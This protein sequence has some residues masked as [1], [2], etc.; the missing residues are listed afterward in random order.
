MS[1]CYYISKEELKNERNF[2]QNFL[3]EVQKDFREEWN[4][5]FDYDLIGSGKRRLVVKKGNSPW[6]LDYRLSFLSKKVDEIKKSKELFKLKNNVKEFI[7]NH[8]NNN[9]NAKLSTSVVTLTKYNKKG[10]KI[11]SYDFAIVNKNNQILKHKTENDVQWNEIAN[12]PEALSR[13][14]EIKYQDKWDYFREKF[15][16]KKC[17]NNDN[18]S[19]YSILAMCIKETLEHFGE[20]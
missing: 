16:E 20:W 4:F 1:N 10:D 2:V 18:L 17:D 6:D 15:K 13:Y 19:G 5:S 11:M 8:T 14:N 9:Y 12:A 3:N 7:N